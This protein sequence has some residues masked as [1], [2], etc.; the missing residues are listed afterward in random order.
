MRAAKNKTNIL[1]REKVPHGIPC[2]VILTVTY[3]EEEFTQNAI[4]IRND[5]KIITVETKLDV[6]RFFKALAK[7]DKK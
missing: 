7:H 2:E 6:T 3:N 1:D 4:V 5:N